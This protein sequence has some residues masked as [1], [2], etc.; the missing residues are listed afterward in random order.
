VLASNPAR[1][2]STPP[3]Q[4]YVKLKRLIPASPRQ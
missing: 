2:A 1:P 4:P 3:T